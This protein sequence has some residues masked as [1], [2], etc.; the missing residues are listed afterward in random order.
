MFHYSVSIACA[1]TNYHNLSFSDFIPPDFK[2]SQ[3]ILCAITVAWEGM[4]RSPPGWVS[5]GWKVPYY[6]SSFKAI[7]VIIHCFEIVIVYSRTLTTLSSP[8]A[9]KLSS[10]QL[11]YKLQCGVLLMSSGAKYAP[12]VFDFKSV[13]KAHKLRPRAEPIVQVPRP[14]L[15][16]KNAFLIEKKNSCELVKSSEPV[17]KIQASIKSYFKPVV[18]G[19]ESKRSWWPFLSAAV[20]AWAGIFLI[21]WCECLNRNLIS[22]ELK[23]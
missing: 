23:N 16:R 2:C 10:A 18:L 5:V 15:K 4:G 14:L 9:I 13:L 8:S 7:D 12:Y 20:L 6:G 1:T 19:S 11:K 21:I 22:I 17:A 3:A